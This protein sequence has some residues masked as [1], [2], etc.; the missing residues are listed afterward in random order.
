[1]SRNPKG[2]KRLN[3]GRSRSE[4]HAPTLL[5]EISEVTKNWNPA[6]E[7]ALMVALSFHP[8]YIPLNLGSQ[9]TG[10]NPVDG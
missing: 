7:V 4:I 9:P 5:R 6:K 8:L 10:S 2:N 3:A 1:V